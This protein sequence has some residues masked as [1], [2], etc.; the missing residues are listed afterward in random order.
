[1]AKVGGRRAVVGRAVGGGRR[2]V[3]VTGARRHLLADVARV[4]RLR[5]ELI[6]ELGRW[7]ESQL[8]ALFVA[9][10]QEAGCRILVTRQLSADRMRLTMRS[11]AVFDDGRDSVE[12]VQEFDRIG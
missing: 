1:M 5:I 10:G 9:M 7:S 2:D 11:R 3:E 12:A 8:A 6:N 4:M